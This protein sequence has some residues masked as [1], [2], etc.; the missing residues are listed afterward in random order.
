MRG[1]VRDSQIDVDRVDGKRAQVA[2]SQVESLGVVIGQ[3]A[4]QVGK[5]RSTYILEGISQLTATP[6]PKYGRVRG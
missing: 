5:S 2:V 1:F 3:Q 6:L 4:V